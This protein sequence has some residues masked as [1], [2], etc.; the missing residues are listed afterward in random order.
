VSVPAAKAPDFE[1]PPQMSARLWILAGLG[2]LAIHVGCIALAWAHLRTDDTDDDLGA[3][4]IEIGLEMLAPHRETTDLPPGPEAEA[5]AASPEV[6]PQK[7][8]VEQTD[9][10]KAV[11]TETEDPDRLV[12]PTESNKP[13]DDT[14]KVEAVQAAPSNE[15]IASEETTAPSVEAALEAP[16][17]VAP[18]QGSGESARRIRATWEKQLVAHLDRHKRYPA[19]RSHQS[20]QIL[21][22]LVLDRTGHVVSTGILK[23][24]GDA[25][26]DQA[27]LAMVRRSDPVPVPPP[28]VAD[29]GLS[30]TLP[31][32]FR[33]KGRS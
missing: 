12:S 18:V 22:S 5:S 23:G 14:I 7:E 9:L 6:A 24:S 16:R 1:S 3:P 28:L 21:V 8:V 20:A 17:A 25:A 15:A 29:E 13:K 10:P 4:A 30:F 19:S 33:V 2:A 31:V 32:V 26:F 11:P 27:A